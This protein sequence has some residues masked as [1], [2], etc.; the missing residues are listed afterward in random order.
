MIENVPQAIEGKAE[1]P[2]YVPPVVRT[3]SETEVLSA[4]QVT[5]AGTST[6]WN[7]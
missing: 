5:A 7:M 2:E 6:W 4:F 1:L 3:M